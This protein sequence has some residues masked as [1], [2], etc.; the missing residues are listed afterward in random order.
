MAEIDALLLS[1]GPPAETQS[2]DAECA[3][4]LAAARA[5]A[6]D[7]TDP[8][9]FM[10]AGDVGTA[11]ALGAHGCERDVVAAERYLRAGASG[12]DVASARHLGLLL[13]ELGRPEEAAE[14]LR[15]AA[16]SG[17]E[18][19]AEQLKA[20]FAEAQEKEEQVLSLALTQTHPNPSPDPKS[21]VVWVW[22]AR[23]KLQALAS[24]GDARAVEMLEELRQKDAGVAV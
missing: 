13:L 6:D 21:V 10:A 14:S 5:T 19:A 11:L 2:E 7:P 9:R 3:S 16:L 24:R 22:Q 18:E 12:G 4:A 15:A 8:R 23:F 20:L 17:D 1:T